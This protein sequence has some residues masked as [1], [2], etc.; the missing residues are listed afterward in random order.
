MSD[1]AVEIPKKQKKEKK[2]KKE[3]KSRRDTVTSPVEAVQETI[4]TPLPATGIHLI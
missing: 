2:V 3:K 4:A 1:P